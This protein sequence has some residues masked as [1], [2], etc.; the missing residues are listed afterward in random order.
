MMKQ[1]DTENKLATQPL[2]WAWLYLIA[3]A[4]TLLLYLSLCYYF[5]QSLQY[6]LA[7]KQR[8]L[9]RSLFYLLAII[10]FPSINLLRHIQLRLNQTMPLQHKSPLIAA[11]HRY[12]ITVI[13]SMSLIE[14]IA[15]LGFILFIL[16]DG[17]N[18]LYIFESLAALALYLYRPKAEEYQAILSAL[19]QA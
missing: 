1:S 16:G 2:L 19:T 13:V 17:F 15:L 11:K 18:T 5:Q 14:T 6:N 8:V 3:M 10:G 9:I 12:L 4:L 7:E